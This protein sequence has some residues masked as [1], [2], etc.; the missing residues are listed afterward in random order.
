MDSAY[1]ISTQ[2]NGEDSVEQW[3]VLRK[4]ETYLLEDVDVFDRQVI[5]LELGG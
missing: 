1:L 3:Q 2:L 5:S 4:I